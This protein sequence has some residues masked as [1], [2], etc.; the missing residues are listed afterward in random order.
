MRY[1]V[2]RLKALCPTLGKVKIAK[3]AEMLC[4]AVLH[5]GTTTVGR[6]LKEPP[7]PTP[8]EAA[9][10]RDHLDAITASAKEDKRRGDTFRY[11]AHRSAILGIRAQM[12]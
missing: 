1:A 9:K 11:L 5:L 12:A 3:I 6:I 8:A 4:R 2:Q 7:R 10:L